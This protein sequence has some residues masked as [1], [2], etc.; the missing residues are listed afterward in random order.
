MK[1]LHDNI[2]SWIWQGLRV[3]C[4]ILF[5][6]AFLGLVFVV[7]QWFINTPDDPEPLAILLGDIILPFI[8]MVFAGAGY[9][10][11]NQV[12]D[13]DPTLLI[14]LDYQQHNREKLINLVRQEVEHKLTNDL[15]NRI[16]IELRMD[17]FDDALDCSLRVHRNLKNRNRTKTL[18]SNQHIADI[19]INRVHEQL[20]IL[21]APG[22]GKTITLFTLAQALLEHTHEPAKPVPVILNLASW[23]GEYQTFNDW[24][25]SALG[26][27]Y[28]VPSELAKVWVANGQLLPL[29]DGLDEVVSSA[30]ASCVTAIN[31]F[32]R[33]TGIGLAVCCREE[34]YNHIPIKLQLGGAVNL[35]PLTP[36]QIGAYLDRVGEEHIAALR[37][38]LKQDAALHKL[39]KNP[40]FLNIMI[41][42]YYDRDIEEI[43]QFRKKDFGAWRN[44]LLATYVSRVLDHRI[45]D[46]G[47]KRSNNE[48]SGYLKWLA[49][50]MQAN[51]QVVFWIERLQPDL[52]QSKMRF[53]FRLAY[54]LAFGL[55][56]GLI[57]G[58]IVS[59]IF[60]LLFS[61]EPVFGLEG[62]LTFGLAFDRKYGLVSLTF[63]LVVGLI[64]SVRIGLASGLVAAMRPIRPVKT[65][66]LYLTELRH[67]LSSAQNKNIM[68]RYRRWVT[69][70]LASGQILGFA[71]GVLFFLTGIV[72]DLVGS[73]VFFQTCGLAYGLAY[74]LANGA[75]VETIRESVRPNQGIWHTRNHFFHMMGVGVVAWLF[76][77]GLIWLDS[78]IFDP[79]F[80]QVSTFFWPLGFS[81]V[82]YAVWDALIALFKHFILRVMLTRAG[83]IPWNYAA[84]LN[85]CCD[86]VLLERVGGGYRFI[87]VTLRDYFAGLAD[88]SLEGKSSE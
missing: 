63:G 29:L 87:H 20:L 52:L 45:D 70:G 33:A 16:F 25:I 4:V 43:P 79:V 48:I 15:H 77:L 7:V 62:E 19:F 88:A 36:K 74:G 23:A 56:Y 5:V 9:F 41:F 40:L 8:S 24:L 31:E 18:P 59:L 13:Y 14:N 54:G 6:F 37:Q 58:L 76:F 30:Q 49:R 46:A 38:I 81:M 1:W 51:N 82:F 32:R 50:Q 69:F 75:G 53:I 26:D 67:G 39:S 3:F 64:S 10:T 80:T 84:F 86:R 73:L 12:K 42:A 35:K 61:L 72:V 2:P 55:S 17:Q 57:V 71:F 28:D 47:P 65:Q 27:H 68:R 34:D 60:R 22:A 21:G 66:I 78:L 85:Y 44:A 11:V 83:H